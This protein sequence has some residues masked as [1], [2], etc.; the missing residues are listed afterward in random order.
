MLSHSCSLKGE[1]WWGLGLDSFQEGFYVLTRALR[2]QCYGECS[3]LTFSNEILS[4]RC[5][6][7]CLILDGF[8]LFFLLPASGSLRNVGR[9]ESKFLAILS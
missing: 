7:E 9:K 6:R 1:L 8:S 3:K 2:T 5:D 4:G